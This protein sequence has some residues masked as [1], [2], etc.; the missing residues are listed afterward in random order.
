VIRGREAIGGVARFPDSPGRLGGRVLRIQ[1][2]Q[3][4]PGALGTLQAWGQRFLGTRSLEIRVPQ[5]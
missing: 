1:I 4:N 5:P 3:T 2:Q